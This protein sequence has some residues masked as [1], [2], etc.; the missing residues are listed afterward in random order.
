M[1]KLADMKYSYMN[2]LKPLV[3]VDITR[4]YKDKVAWGFLENLKDGTYLNTKYESKIVNFTPPKVVVFSNFM[5]TV[6]EEG[7]EVLSRD[8]WIVKELKNEKL[9]DIT[10]QLFKEAEIDVTMTDAFD[11][12]LN[13]P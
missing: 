8:R 3:F 12:G 9:T 5:P 1:G 2:L 7:E 10:A 11:A 13:F 6:L 4:W